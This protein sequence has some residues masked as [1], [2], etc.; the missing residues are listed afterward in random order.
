MRRLMSD[1]SEELNGRRRYP[2]IR[3]KP[4]G[5]SGG[6]GVELVFGKHG[7]IREGLSDVLDVEV[8]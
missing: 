1:A 8:R 6:Q 3:E 5:G 7:R 4:H 2:G